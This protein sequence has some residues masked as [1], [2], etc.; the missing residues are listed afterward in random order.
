MLTACCVFALAKQDGVRILSNLRIDGTVCVRFD[1]SC[2]WL[3]GMHSIARGWSANAAF[4]GS[5]G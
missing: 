3:L 4:R 2:P 5:V 1:L